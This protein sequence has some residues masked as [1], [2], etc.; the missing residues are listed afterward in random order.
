M[1]MVSDLD[2]GI[3]TIGDSLTMAIIIPIGE[4][5]M[6]GAGAIHIM[7]MATDIL[8]MAMDTIIIIITTITMGFH[9]I[10]EEEIQ[11]T[12][13]LKPV[14]GQTTFQPEIPTAVPNFP[15]A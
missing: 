3:P 9:I 5:V 15:D 7:D 4:L 1:V 8:I 12:T 6:A 13:E 2:I 10:G 14:E 11:I